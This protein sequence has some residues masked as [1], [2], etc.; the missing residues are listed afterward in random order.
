MWTFGD[1]RGLRELDLNTGNKRRK[2]PD[3]TPQSVN[4]E[5][6]GLFFPISFNRYISSVD[7][8]KRIAADFG[9][10]I[11]KDLLFLVALST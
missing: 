3:Y 8:I 11:F 6:P 10:L 2:S 1:L 4:Y 7:I 9:S 5:I